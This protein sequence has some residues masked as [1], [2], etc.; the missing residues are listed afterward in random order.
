MRQNEISKEFERL[1]I[2]SERIPHYESPSQLAATYK[3]CTVYEYYPVTYT[4]SSFSE[5]KDK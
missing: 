2:S 4:A 1:N 5:T 3:R